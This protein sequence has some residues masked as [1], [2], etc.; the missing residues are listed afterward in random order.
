MSG[1]ERVRATAMAFADFLDRSDFLS[2]AAML[3]SDCRYVTGSSIRPEGTLVGP[4][5]ILASYRR[6]DE[7]ARSLFDR[8][9]YSSEVEAVR[10]NS[11]VIRFTDVIEKTGEKHTYRCFQRIT[12]DENWRIEGIVHQDIP[13][14]MTALRAFLGRVGVTL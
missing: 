6:H 7:Q 4:H 8:V 5:A 3:A 13:I 10:D 11:A 12:F 1:E 2:A 14:E 9:E